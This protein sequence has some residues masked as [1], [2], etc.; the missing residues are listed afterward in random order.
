[1]SAAPVDIVLELRLL[2][3]FLGEKPQFGWWSSSFFEPAAMQF[4]EPVFGRTAR[5][6]QYNGV[7]EAARRVH[8]EHVGIGQVFHLFRLPQESEQDLHQRAGS[9]GEA[10]L[11]NLGG[12]ED[13]LTRLRE[14]GDAQPAIGEGPQAVGS[15]GDARKPASIKKLASL[16]LG[17]FNAGT[18]LYPYFTT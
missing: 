3:G 9:L 10:V 11:V 17:A 5:L 4:L 14:L 2:V 18:R 8:D 13:A 12:R 16:Y 1:M 7:R 15:I 6:A